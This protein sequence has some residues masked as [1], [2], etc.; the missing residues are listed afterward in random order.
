MKYRTLTQ[1]K[2]GKQTLLEQLKT[3]DEPSAVKVAGGAKPNKA[4]TAADISAGEI[5]S[6]CG[7]QFKKRVKQRIILK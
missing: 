7:F 6:P 2:K 4:D 3:L 1:Q 5:G